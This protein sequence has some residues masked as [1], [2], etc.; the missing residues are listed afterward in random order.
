MRYGEGKIRER[1]QY[2]P[3]EMSAPSIWQAYIYKN[4]DQARADR[5]LPGMQR[6]IAQGLAQGLCTHTVV[7]RARFKEIFNENLEIE[8]VAW[9][10]LRMVPRTYTAATT[11]KMINVTGTM[12]GKQRPRRAV[13]TTHMRGDAQHSEAPELKHGKK[14][15]TTTV[16]DQDTVALRFSAEK[17]YQCGPGEDAYPVWQAW[18]KQH[19]KNVTSWARENVGEVEAK[20][21]TRVLGFREE[22]GRTT[23]D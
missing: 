16:S 11:D 3:P 19:A 17:T 7:C 23:E 2:E 5:R 12:Q 10:L 15:I 14:T 20:E 18:V 1:S 21:I 22:A 9:K 8:N 4:S 6:V 13:Q